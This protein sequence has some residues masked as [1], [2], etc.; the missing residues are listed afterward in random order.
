MFKKMYIIPIICTVMLTGCNSSGINQKRT[1]EKQYADN[2]FIMIK[3]EESGDELLSEVYVKY[4]G[5]DKNKITSALSSSVNCV[6]G[7]VPHLF[8]PL[9]VCRECHA[10]M[11]LGNTTLYSS[12]KAVKALSSPAGRKP[13]ELFQSSDP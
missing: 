10:L 3:N 4:E 6:P 2:T 8:T 1:N 9:R 11:C 13:D 5:K 7:R 12:P